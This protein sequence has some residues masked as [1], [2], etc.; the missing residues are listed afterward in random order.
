MQ[1]HMDGLQRML[2]RA[3]ARRQ[4]NK[5]MAEKFGADARTAKSTAVLPVLFNQSARLYDYQWEG[6]RFMARQT[7]TM[8]ST[9][10]ADEMGLGKT[11]QV[12]ARHSLEARHTC[13][14]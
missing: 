2:Q 10:L 3:K 9:L 14:H 12:C 7:A 5:T 4:F 6:F 13:A 11:V 8:Q 1:R